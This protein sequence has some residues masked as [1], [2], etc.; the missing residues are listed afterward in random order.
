MKTFLVAA[1][2]F[3]ATAAIAGD[4]DPIINRP[5]ICS[6]PPA[7]VSIDHCHELVVIDGSQGSLFE[8]LTIGPGGRICGPAIVRG[9][10]GAP[11]LKLDAGACI[12]AQR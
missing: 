10:Q 12:P 2:I 11:A 7:G 3:A 8:V 4:A 9:F 5:P 6:P 1:A